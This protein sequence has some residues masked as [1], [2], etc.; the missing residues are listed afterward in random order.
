MD[1]VS[2]NENFQ[3]LTD[4]AVDAPEG[5]HSAHESLFAIYRDIESRLTADDDD[6]DNLIATQSVVVRSAAML[7][8]RT[9][10]DV[11]FKLALWRWDAPNIDT[12]IDEMMPYEAAAFSALNDLVD[13]TAEAG[14]LK[15]GDTRLSAVS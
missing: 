9:V 5:E 8:A 4:L 2:L 13:L 12:P 7:P 6:A 3:E 14:V 10:R 15:S 11:L 1:A